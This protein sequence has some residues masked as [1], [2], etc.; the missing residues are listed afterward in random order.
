[1]RRSYRRQTWSPDQKYPVAA[2]DF[3]EKSRR[4]DVLRSAGIWRRAA[5]LGAVVV[6]VFGVLMVAQQAQA[7]TEPNSDP[8]TGSYVVGP[9]CPGNGIGK[10]A[11]TGSVPPSPGLVS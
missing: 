8:V 10:F 2:P 4:L 11:W 5:S 1:M 9:N 3:R 7:A 6:L